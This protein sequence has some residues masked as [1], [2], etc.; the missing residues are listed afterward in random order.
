MAKKTLKKQGGM[1]EMRELNKY[2]QEKLK[3]F[4]EMY[5]QKEMQMK[6]NLYGK[7]RLLMS[8]G[9]YRR[10]LIIENIKFFLEL[11]K[12]DIKDYIKDT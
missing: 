5:L 10:Y 3:L 12:K 4:E 9:K 2:E 7:F 8:D 11:S 1:I 6:K